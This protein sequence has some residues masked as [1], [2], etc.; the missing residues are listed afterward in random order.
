MWTGPAAGIPGPGSGLPGPGAGLLG[1]GSGLLG[2]GLD[3]PDCQGMAWAY[4]DLP[5]PG[6]GLP[7]PTWAYPGLVWA[8]PGLLGPIRFYMSLLGPTR[9]YPGLP[10]LARPCPSL[11]ERLGPTRKGGEPPLIWR[12]DSQRRMHWLYVAVGLVLKFAIGANE[13]P[14]GC[15]QEN[16]ERSCRFT[17][18]K[19]LKPRKFSSSRWANKDCVRENSFFLLLRSK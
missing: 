8:Y 17:S 14:S 2:P 5:E 1:P 9:V 7:G 10:G 4:P 15:R 16:R 13:N 6:L 11:T 18:F 12:K 3:L 19:T